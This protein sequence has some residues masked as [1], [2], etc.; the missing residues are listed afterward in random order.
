MRRIPTGSEPRAFVLALALV[1]PLTARADRRDLYTQVAAPCWASS[2]ATRTVSA[3]PWAWVC[4]IPSG[5][6]VLG[7]LIFPSRWG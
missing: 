5:P 2:C 3:S 7:S 4:A 6:P 1:I